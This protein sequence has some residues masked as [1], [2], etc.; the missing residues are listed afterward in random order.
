M[1]QIRRGFYPYVRN[2]L[3]KYY[4]RSSVKSSKKQ[5]KPSARLHGLRQDGSEDGKTSVEF[6][7]ASRRACDKIFN[8]C[9]AASVFSWAR[10]RTYS[11]RASPAGRRRQKRL[12][13]APRLALRLYNTPWESCRSKE[14][15]AAHR[16]PAQAAQQSCPRA[17]RR[18]TSVSTRR[19]PD[20]RHRRAGI[21]AKQSERQ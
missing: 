13:A 15:G 1:P 6:S 3:L 11:V 9:A 4:T 17:Q 8:P 14:K 16:T 19:L 12:G 20:K 21:C 18:E 7:A 5:K 2:S 10:A